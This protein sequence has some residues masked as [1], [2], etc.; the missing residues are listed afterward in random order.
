MR[1][2]VGLEACAACDQH[3]LALIPLERLSGERF[4]CL[5]CGENEAFVSAW[6]PGAWLLA[7][8]TDPL[9]RFDL[10]REHYQLGQPQGVQ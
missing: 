1:W 3:S 8:Y 9:L 4:T 2:L 10:A 7:S 6:W 5:F